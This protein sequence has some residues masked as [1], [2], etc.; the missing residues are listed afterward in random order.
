M[1]VLD[2]NTWCSHSTTIA[3][4][5]QP[6]SELVY[7]KLDTLLRVNHEDCNDFPQKITTGLIFLPIAETH[8]IIDTHSLFSGVYM[9][10]LVVAVVL[11]T[12]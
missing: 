7:K 8:L 9:Y 10:D 1:S 3:L 4:D 11:R 12:V 2:R 6:F 5:I